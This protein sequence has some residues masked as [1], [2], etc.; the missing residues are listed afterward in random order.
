MSYF[1]TPWWMSP[2][3]SLYELAMTPHRYMSSYRNPSYYRPTQY[4]NN[5]PGYTTVV[6]EPRSSIVTPSM[7]PTVQTS[8]VMPSVSN[9]VSA[10]SSGGKRRY[11]R[12][13]KKR[14]KVQRKK[15]TRKA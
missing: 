15:L 14:E 1:Q 2:S 7:T 4:Y 9:A 12:S 3:F 11:N 8:A 6:Y 5:S 10:P 13:M